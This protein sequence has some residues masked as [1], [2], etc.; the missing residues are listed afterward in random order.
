MGLRRRQAGCGA[1]TVDGRP[2]VV[3]A[4]DP[5]EFSPVEAVR[6][7]DV[8]VRDAYFSVLTRLSKAYLLVLRAASATLGEDFDEE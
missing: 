5:N 2:G 6:S 1:V 4:P 7:N 8:A 3:A